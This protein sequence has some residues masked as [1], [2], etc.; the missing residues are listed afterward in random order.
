M[1]TTTIHATDFFARRQAKRDFASLL[2]IKA[3]S[4]RV[5]YDSFFMSRYGYCKC[6][7]G[8]TRAVFFKMT[9]AGP[10][11]QK[12][13]EARTRGALMYAICEDCGKR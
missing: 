5:A 4:V 9:N 11:Q 12:K 1:S 3:E 2:N 7:C 10:R 6:V 8:D 13:I